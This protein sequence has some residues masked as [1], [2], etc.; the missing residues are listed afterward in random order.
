MLAKGTF[1]GDVSSKYPSP[2]SK[3][4]LLLWQAI[5]SYTRQGAL[6][7]CLCW[8]E[9]HLQALPRHTLTLEPLLFPTQP[10]ELLLAQEDTAPSKAMGFWQKS[11]LQ[12]QSGRGRLAHRTQGVIRHTGVSAESIF[13]GLLD[14]DRPVFQ[15]VP[16]GI[17]QQGEPGSSLI[18]H[19][20]Q[21]LTSPSAKPPTH[22]QG[23][24]HIS[25]RSPIPLPTSKAS[26]QT[27]ERG[28]LGNISL[29]KHNQAPSCSPKDLRS[30][31]N[32]K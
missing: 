14:P 6:G 4:V 32:T 2:V 1:Q 18:Q 15:Q 8:W 22:A 11:Y 17:L 29:F 12:Y 5:S 31:S 30:E 10:Q 24:C 16:A 13:S 23:G 26:P 3:P 19:T 9:A 7:V 27:V 25:W 20:P 28:N 21:V